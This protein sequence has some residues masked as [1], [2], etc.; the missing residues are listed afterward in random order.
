LHF[1]HHAIDID[2]DDAIVRKCF[3]HDNLWNENGVRHDVHGVV[4]TNAQRLTIE[5]CTIHNCSGDCVQGERGNWDMLRIVNCELTNAPLP[6]DLGGFQRGTYPGENAFDSK[7]ISGSRGRVAVVNCRMHGFRTKLRVYTSAIVLKENVDA[8]IDSCDFYDSTIAL[9]LRGFSRGMAMWPVVM[10]CV[11]R[12]NDVAFRL[13]DR[14][15]KFRLLHCTIYDNRQQTIWAPGSG[16]PWRGNWDNSEWALINNLWI[17]PASVPEIATREDFGA[18]GNLVMARSDVDSR[19]VPLDPVQG[20]P[21]PPV[22]DKWY[23]P[24]GL[25]VRDKR[26]VKRKTPG[27]VGAFE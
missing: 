7:H 4:T 26:G 6:R 8:V 9:R 27:H 23:E 14:L 24:T 12:G 3:I 20:G 17:D 16:R 21:V 1:A 18:A 25:V 5:Q 10:N 15:Q 22:V 2:G 11:I 13:E 19:L